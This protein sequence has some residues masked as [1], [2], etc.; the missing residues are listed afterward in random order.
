MDVPKTEEA[1]FSNFQINILGI[2]QCT[3]HKVKVKNGGFV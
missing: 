1:F 2:S 3:C